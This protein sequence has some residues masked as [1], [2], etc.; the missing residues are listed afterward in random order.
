VRRR[1][2]KKQPRKWTFAG[3][4]AHQDYLDLVRR[5]TLAGQARLERIRREMEESGQQ[6]I[7]TEQ[8][9]A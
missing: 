2:K 9:S 3:R 7:D 8:D 6:E 1:Q 5:S 4:K